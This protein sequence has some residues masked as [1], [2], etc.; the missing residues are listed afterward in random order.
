MPAIDAW[1]SPDSGGRRALARYVYEC[2]K[3]TDRLV[4]TW[5]APDIYFY[6]GRAFSGRQLF[7]FPGYYASAGEQDASVERMR[8]DSVPIVIQRTNEFPSHFERVHRYIVENYRLTPEVRFGEAVDTPYRVYVDTRLAP[9][10]TY[11]R[12]SL[13]CYR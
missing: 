2:T 6:A 10:G 8:R 3:P 1:A 11:R 9:T 13:P 5:F 7:W 12:F 4:V